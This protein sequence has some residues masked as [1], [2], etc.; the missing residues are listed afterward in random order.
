MRKLIFRKYAAPKDAYYIC[1]INI[2]SDKVFPLH[3]HDYVEI[4][5]IEEGEGIHH[6]NGEQILIKRGDLVFMRPEDHHSFRVTTPEPMVLVNISFPELDFTTFRDTYVPDKNQYWYNSSELPEILKLKEHQI[7]W[8]EAQADELHKTS[9]TRLFRDRFLLNLFT[10][11]HKGFIKKEN[12]KGPSWL[13]EALELIKKPEHFCLGTKEF[14]KLSY[15][16][17]EHV[18]RVVK[19]VLGKRPTEIVN[20]ARMEHAAHSLT[21]SKKEILDIVSDCGFQSIGHFYQCFHKEFKMS[22]RKYRIQK[23]SIVGTLI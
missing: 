2:H 6:V 10:E 12:F 7:R 1:R 18:A 4:F 8:L 20:K 21:M 11:L 19:S 9:R 16:S 3:S 5:W 15:R 17:P 13:E 22:P 23:Q 14:A